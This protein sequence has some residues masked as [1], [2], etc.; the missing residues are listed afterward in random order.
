MLRASAAVSKI[1]ATEG[2]AALSDHDGTGQPEEP[3]LQP[4]QGRSKNFT[5]A[6]LSNHPW[7]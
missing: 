7:N 5:S 1:G 2:K 6:N 4:D 3:T